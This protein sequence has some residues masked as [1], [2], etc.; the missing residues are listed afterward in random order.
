MKA[1]R[2][3]IILFVLFVILAATYFIMGQRAA[4]AGSKQLYRFSNDESLQEIRVNNR[5]GAFTFN[6][7]GDT[8]VITAP[9]RYRANQ[10][11]T[12]IMEEFLLNMPINRVLDQEIEAYGFADPLATV[13]LVTSDGVEHTF[14]IGSRTSS[15][16]Q[17]YLRDKESGNILISDIGAVSQFDGSLTAYRDTDLFSTDLANV[18]QISYFDDQDKRITVARDGPQNWRLTYPYEA[19]AR[20]I[21]LN[22][23]VLGMNEWKAVGY[24]DEGLDFAA[25]GL[26]QPLHTLEVTD[27]AGKEQRLE[28]GDTEDGSIFVRIGGP[29]D[30]V[31]LFAIDVDF[32][33]LAA[34]KLLFYQPLRTTIDKVAK[35]EVEYPRQTVLF[36]LDHATQPPLI[37]ANGTAVAYEDF[38]SFFIR[39]IGLSAGGHDPQSAAGSAEMT[40]TTTYNDGTTKR[41]SLLDR[42]TSTLFIED[43]DETVFYIDREKI[44][45]LI[46]RLEVALGGGE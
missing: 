23:L 10:Q 36:E 19:P 43:E 38:L 5:F 37:T 32:D 22:E 40:L 7:E 16:A 44:A 18:A 39:Y 25:M 3:V 9:D 11:K 42:D 33:P 8:W 29:Q 17:V 30:I 14:D 27:K 45:Q 34:D 2:N 28:F 26:D 24:P 1:Y 35:I 20:F 12:G 13:T 31:K 41:V 21:E 4:P 46:Y 15:Q 6:K